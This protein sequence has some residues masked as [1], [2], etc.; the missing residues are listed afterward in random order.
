MSEHIC[1][2]AMAAYPILAATDSNL[3]GGAATQLVLLGKALRDEGYR[4]T[5]IVNDYGQKERE[6]HEGI[7]TVKCKF[8]YF[9]GSN[10]WY[11]PDT[12]SLIAKLKK[13]R[14]SRS[15]LFVVVGASLR[16]RNIS[17]SPSKL[18]ARWTPSRR[19]TAK[20]V[21]STIEKS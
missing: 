13:A 4:L 18:A 7:E 15:S 17:K 6:N 5:F 11:F 12:L 20:L 3:G 1:I 10:L 14:S 19:M 8:R 21:R 16:S 2:V 9:G